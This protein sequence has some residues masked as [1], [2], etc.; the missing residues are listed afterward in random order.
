MSITLSGRFSGVFWGNR[1]SMRAAASESKQGWPGEAGQLASPISRNGVAKTTF[2][3]R[4][5]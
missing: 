5:S 1:Q 2:P 4:S 3:S